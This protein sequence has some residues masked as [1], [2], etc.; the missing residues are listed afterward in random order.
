MGRFLFINGP[1][2]NLLGERETSIYGEVSLVE[3]E[4]KLKSLGENDKVEVLFF[5]S[6]EEGKLIDR[7]HRAKDEKIKCIII[8]AGAYTHTSIAIR[9]ALL[10]VKIPFVEVHI[11]NI[12]KREKFRSH[13]Y[14]SDIADGVISGFGYLSYELAYIYALKR[15][16]KV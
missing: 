1:N 7:I 11:S 2:L 6:N 12:Y 10:G 14:L 4:K 16:G 15:Y 13:S 9:D 5:Q 8:N 3:M